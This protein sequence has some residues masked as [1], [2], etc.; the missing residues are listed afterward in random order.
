MKTILFPVLLS[1]L[2]LASFGQSKYAVV[3]G[4]EGPYKDQYT[5]TA[6]LDEKTNI[7]SFET[8]AAVT[9]VTLEV[10]TEKE[11]VT[12][13]G[14]EYTNTYKKTGNKYSYDLK[15]PLLKNKHAY[16]LKVSIGNNGVPLAEY[17]FKQTTAPVATEPAEK[18]STIPAEEVKNADGATVI[19]TNINCTAG[20]T[21]VVNALKAMEGVFDVKM[22][23]ATGKLTIKYSSDGTAY[24][25]ILTTITENGFAANGQK[26]AATSTNPCKTKKSN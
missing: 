5:F 16:W 12:R 23:I 17:F 14:Q 2:G 3:G 25:T 9:V 26:P 1:L 6:K 11:L 15:K 10:Y 24:T 7:L 8:N 19:K 18:V 22:D 20:K 4:V 21:K 13:K